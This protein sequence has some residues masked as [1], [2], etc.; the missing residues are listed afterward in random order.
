S[1]TVSQDLSI[2]QQKRIN[3]LLEKDKG[4]DHV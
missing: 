4:D 2:D 3:E 1:E